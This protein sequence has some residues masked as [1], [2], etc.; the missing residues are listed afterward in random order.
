MLAVVA[1]LSVILTKV[2]SEIVKFCKQ[3]NGCFINFC[4]DV[5]ADFLL[6]LQDG[7]EICSSPFSLRAR[8]T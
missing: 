6:S 4:L 8:A 2:E 1:E 3:D 5:W 7:L